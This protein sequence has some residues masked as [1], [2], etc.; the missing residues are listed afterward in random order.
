[1]SQE[2]GCQQGF[3]ELPGT[4]TGERFSVLRPVA[5][6]SELSQPEP[7][8]FRPD[9]IRFRPDPVGF[10]PDPDRLRPDSIGFRPD[11]VGFQPDPVGFRLETGAMRARD[12]Q[13]MSLAE[14]VLVCK[15]VR[16]S[17]L[18]KYEVYMQLLVD[19]LPLS[20]QSHSLREREGYLD[21][22]LV[23]LRKLCVK[24]REIVLEE[25]E[26][27]VDYQGEAQELRRL[28]G[29]EEELAV[30]LSYEK[31]AL[32]VCLAQ[33]D[34]DFPQRVCS[35]AG[36]IGG[37]CEAS[38]ETETGAPL[39]TKIVSV[40]DVLKDIESWWEPMVAEYQALVCEKQVVS[41]VT[42]EELS[43]REAAGEVFQVIPAKLIFTL[44]AFT[45]RHKVRCVGCGNYLGEGM[46][47]A[48]QL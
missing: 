4:E 27:G 1:M 44:K 24:Q 19:D 42:A 17:E 15:A 18:A 38:I 13:I 41:P 29:M 12:A 14:A 28:E 10:R 35:V 46:Y 45:A 22:V 20:I 26:H 7:L 2:V 34:R 30:E 32:Q 3:A 43:R 5:E 47:S 40:E 8:G 21:Q 48:N 9:P 36:D 37:G 16:E 33:A 31:E 11:P 25:A 6:E 39:Q 23:E